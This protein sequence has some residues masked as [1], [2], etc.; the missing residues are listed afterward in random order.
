MTHLCYIL[1]GYVILWEVVPCPL[2][3]CFTKTPNTGL[4]PPLCTVC[5]SVMLC[6]TDS[7]H[8]SFSEGWL[9]FLRSEVLRGLFSLQLAVTAGKMS[10]W[11]NCYYK[12]A[13][14]GSSLLSEPAFSHC[15]RAN[16]DKQ[17][18]H[19]FCSALW[20]IMGLVELFHCGQK[21]K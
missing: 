16:A 5:S 13:H 10:P 9:C 20:L 1:K 2:P 12:K 11:R 19:I 4:N 3:S 21:A 8:F 7:N 15:L 6:P 14:P 18:L 17:L